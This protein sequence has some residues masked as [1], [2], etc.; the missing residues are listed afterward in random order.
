MLQTLRAKTLGELNVHER[1]LLLQPGG[2]A[3]ECTADIQDL[4]LQEL[5]HGL[6]PRA[7]QAELGFGASANAQ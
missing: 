4:V 7:F 2:S 6:P 1:E 3:Q 5:E